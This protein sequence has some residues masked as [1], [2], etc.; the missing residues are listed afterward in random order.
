MIFY[1]LRNIFNCVLLQSVQHT[2]VRNLLE[3]NALKSKPIK[4][5][6]Q[7]YLALHLA[8]LETRNLFSFVHHCNSNLKKCTGED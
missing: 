7:P 4:L 3:K 5:M 2:A 1:Q 8:A 6:L